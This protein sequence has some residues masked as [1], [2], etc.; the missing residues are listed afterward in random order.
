MKEKGFWPTTGG[1]VTAIVMGLVVASCS[2]EPEGT[3]MPPGMGETL[4]IKVDGMQKGD[5]GKT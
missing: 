3:S 2:K 1:A 4:V 5:G